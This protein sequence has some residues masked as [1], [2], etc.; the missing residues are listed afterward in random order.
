M[1][2]IEKLSRIKGIPPRIQLKI[3]DSQTGSLP[4]IKRIAS[5][6]RKGGYPIVFDDTNTIVFSSS[7]KNVYFSTGL[8]ISSQYLTTENTSSLIG[9]GSIRSGI[10]DSQV[11]PYKDRILTYYDIINEYLK[12]YGLLPY[13]PPQ[14]LQ[15]FRDFNQPAV[16]GKSSGNAYFATGTL[17]SVIGEGGFDQPLWS[18]NLLEMNFDIVYQTD[19]DNYIVQNNNNSATAKT[20]I[21]PSSFTYSKVYNYSDVDYPIWMHDSDQQP[22][23]YILPI[24]GSMLPV[25]G[26]IIPSVDKY[27]GAPSVM[28]ASGT[29]GFTPGF[30]VNYT[31]LGIATNKLTV[32]SS[33]FIN[34]YFTA[35]L[36]GVTTS[37]NLLLEYCSRSLLYN[38][39]EYMAQMAKPMNNFAFPYG[40]QYHAAKEKVIKMKDYI[41][42]PFLVEKIVMQLSGVTFTMSD[43]INCN[44]TNSFYQKQGLIFPFVANSIFILNQR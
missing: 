18:K 12:G 40:P 29:F 44:T 21:N 17:E 14:T 15:P 2:R 6:N 22:M 28:Y 4:T 41:D 3:L 23:L 31:P 43:L 7:S 39:I 25:G 33:N 32:S 10:G 35:S 13:S 30:G 16:D 27:G 42:K 34:S 8:E 38:N 19:A 36:M 5:D 1:A 26:R 20:N 37:Y 24:L 9:T 11:I